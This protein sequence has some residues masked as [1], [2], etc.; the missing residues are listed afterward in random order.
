MATESNQSDFV[1]TNVRFF[2]EI[3]K[4]SYEVMRK[5]GRP[6]NVSLYTLRTRPEKL[7]FVIPSEYDLPRKE[8][9]LLEKVRD[10]LS[11]HRPKDASFMDAE[12][13]REY[14][15][16]F[17]KQV[18]SKFVEE[19]KLDVDANRI[20][21][22]ADVFRDTLQDLESLRIFFWTTGFRISM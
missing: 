19:Q 5:G 12:T 4:E 9:Y 20:E 3:A 7:Y 16:R 18:I 2:Y 14:F 1:H 8:L 10:H 13:A 15:Q 6:M 22:L 17:G 11:K 21:Y